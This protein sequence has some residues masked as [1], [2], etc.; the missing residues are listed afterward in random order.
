M[1]RAPTKIFGQKLLAKFSG[2]KLGM[3][4]FEFSFVFR[5]TVNGLLKW[6][7][8]SCDEI[9]LIHVNQS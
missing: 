9:S 5:H 7:L 2:K 4:Y 1:R 6:I 8:V 3:I